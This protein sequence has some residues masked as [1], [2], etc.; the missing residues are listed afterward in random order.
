MGT[1][2]VVSTPIG[3]LEDISLRALRVL[4]EVPLI[5]AEDTRH[6][7]KLLNHFNISTRTISYHQHSAPS[8]VEELLGELQKGDLA[9]VTDA[10][11][12]ALS[13]PGA[14]L[15]AAAAA[16]GFN[17]VAI[18]GASALLTLV[19]VS[20]LD[21]TRFSYIGFMPRK[22]KERA[23]LIE[24]AGHADWPFV[25]YESPHRMAETL[26]DLH[27]ALGDRTVVVGRE[28]TKLHEEIFRGR[29]S[30]AAAHFASQPVRGEVAILVDA[31]HGENAEQLA[32]PAAQVDLD[33]LLRDLEA[34]GLASKDAARQAAKVVGISTR[35]AYNRLMK[36]RAESE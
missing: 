3:N 6:T 25:L 15:V 13:D 2:F 33:S 4:G 20:G 16:A 1:L 5:A 17:V 29:L 7:R 8:R 14:E 23:K 28:L 32:E 9:I 21:A 18:P 27:A 26:N 11:T 22:G 24:Q 30:D 10:G 34:Q 12:P 19:A 31:G 36:I 35:D